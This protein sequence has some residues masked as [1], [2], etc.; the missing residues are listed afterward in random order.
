MPLS[1]TRPRAA[2]FNIALVVKP[3]T[4]SAA[5]AGSTSSS[6]R[7]SR[8]G[9]RASIDASIVP[10]STLTRRLSGRYEQKSSQRTR[11]S[12]GVAGNPRNRPS[13]HA[14]AS[15]EGPSAPNQAR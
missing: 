6:T 13:A 5:G 9:A 2:S 12:E 3:R 1:G 15:G 8:N 14:V 4:L 7:R 11:F 10:R